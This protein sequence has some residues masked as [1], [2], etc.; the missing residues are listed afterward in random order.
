MIIKIAKELYPRFKGLE[1]FFE[2]TEDEFVSSCHSIFASGG[3]AMQIRNEYDLWSD[4]S[5]A[6]K[7]F[8]A[9]G[10]DHPDDMSAEI[11]RK[12][13]RLHNLKELTK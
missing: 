9:L 5:D 11:L 2:K 10:V 1:E 13:Y 6:H 12:V 8:K 4:N 3:I 7:Y